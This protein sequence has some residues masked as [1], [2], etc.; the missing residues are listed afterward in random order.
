MVGLTGVGGGALMTPILL[1][2]FGIAPMAAV[3]T[4]LWFAAITKLFAT[5]VHQRHG[6]IDWQVVKRLW[7]GSLTASVITLAWLH[8]NPIADDSVHLLKGAVAI[9][10][11]VTAIAML[12]QKQLHALGRTFRTTESVKFKNVQGPLTV[13]AGAF[14]GILVTFTS[15]GAGA[16]GA[17]FLVY[18]YPL[19]LT[20]PRLIA[21][22]IVHAILG[23]FSPDAAPVA[24]QRG[25]QPAGQFAGLGAAV[26]V[27]RSEV[28]ACTYLRVVLVLVL[29]AAGG[30]LMLSLL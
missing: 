10:V 9:T 2:V 7:A 30:K 3:G 23:P 29:L 1:L 21:T 4:D 13:A 14:L 6:L 5:P 15:V 28:R 19:R 16:L 25:L 22:D 27:G 17:V 12:F 20:P 8:F 24:R 26:I 18:L 11:M